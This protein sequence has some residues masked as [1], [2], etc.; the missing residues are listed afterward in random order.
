M[1]IS[2]K[3]KEHNDKISLLNKQINS[4]L[5]EQSVDT[6]ISDEILKPINT[7]MDVARSVSSDAPFIDT[8]GDGS[9]SGEIYLEHDEIEFEDD[10]DTVISAKS[11]IRY[12]MS[13]ILELDSE[14]TFDLK[15]DPENKLIPEDLIL[16]VTI[17]HESGFNYK[18]EFTAK[19]KQKNIKTYDEED[20]DSVDMKILSY[21]IF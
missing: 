20:L 4:I 8:G 7:M 16:S 13:N 17:P 11:T 3:L 9:N 5:N 19:L 10:D 14:T 6:G 18:D 21:K 1:D 15:G 2:K 12:R